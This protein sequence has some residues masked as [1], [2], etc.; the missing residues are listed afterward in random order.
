MWNRANGRNKVEGKVDW[1]RKSGAKDL[2]AHPLPPAA[3][4]KY[5]V[6]PFISQ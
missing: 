4:K 1:R 2:S 3:H 5:V 6:D